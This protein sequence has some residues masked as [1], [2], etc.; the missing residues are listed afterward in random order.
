MEKKFMHIN[1]NNEVKISDT[2]N[3]F[4]ERQTQRIFSKLDLDGLLKSAEESLSEAL[5]KSHWKGIEI[6]LG[7]SY[8]KPNSYKY[9]M[10]TTFAYLVRGSKD[11]FLVDLKREATG[12]KEAKVV[13]ILI[14]DYLK[15]I[16]ID[17]ILKNKQIK[18]SE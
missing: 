15:D 12:N 6:K 11:W 4:S 17:T 18:F 16:T 14:P 10:N 2:L 3:I 5:P 13:E 8:Y 7:Y 9:S 1:I